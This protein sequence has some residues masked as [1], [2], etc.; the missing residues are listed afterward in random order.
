MDRLP[1]QLPLLPETAESLNSMES[2]ITSACWLLDESARILAR[3]THA[4]LFV[5]GSSKV[6]ASGSNGEASDIHE[7][8]VGDTRVSTTSTP[9]IGGSE[10]RIEDGLLLLWMIVAL[11]LGHWILRR[12]VFIPL[13]RMCVPELKSDTAVSTKMSA[14]NQTDATNMK[15]VHSRGDNIATATTTASTK[16]T[17]P[18]TP[19]T[20]RRR[21]AV[22][23]TPPSTPGDDGDV[24]ASDE[25]VTEMTSLPAKAATS[26]T[27]TVKPRG[28]SLEIKFS[29]ALFKGIMYSL[30]F[31]VGMYALLVDNYLYALERGSDSVTSAGWLFAAKGS[32]MDGHQVLTSPLTANYEQ[33]PNHL[34]LH[35]IPIHVDGTLQLAR[36]PILFHYVLALAH[37]IY[38]S[39][40]VL[41]GWDGPKQSDRVEM[42][43][44]HAI[45]IA[46][47]TFSWYGRLWRVGAM[48]WRD[49]GRVVVLRLATFES[50]LLA[51]KLL[52]P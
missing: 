5:D 44:H 10:M 47:V 40:L 3:W 50:I 51:L 27:T 36:S 39:I 17:T 7:A 13:A 14:L 41:G 45:T 28:H 20:R 22:P 32:A 9:F 33:W 42:L 24:Y 1:P 4:Y 46:L 18:S 6:S 19:A 43:S 16:A 31:I 12:F 35:D 49:A 11:A 52:L 37:Y 26:P 21:R 25:V 8:A 23:P 2:I 38:A 34:R 15:S 48:V 29:A 30:L